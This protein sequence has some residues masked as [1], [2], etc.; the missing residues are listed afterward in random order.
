MVSFQF[1]YLFQFFFHDAFV[2]YADLLNA[3]SY[4]VKLRRSNLL[5]NDYLLSISV[6][7]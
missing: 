6:L 7:T 3:H 2:C 5:R 1:S 4:G